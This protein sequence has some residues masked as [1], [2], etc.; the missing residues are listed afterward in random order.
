MPLNYG[1]VRHGHSFEDWLKHVH[2]KLAAKIGEQRT[3]LILAR[4]PLWDYWS[5]GYGPDD[6]AEDMAPE[7]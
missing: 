1:G 6:A 2:S 5:S 3:T 4:Q 7:E